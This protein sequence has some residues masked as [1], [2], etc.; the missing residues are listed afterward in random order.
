MALLTDIAIS[1]FAGLAPTPVEAVAIRKYLVRNQ[2][3]NLLHFVNIGMGSNI[4]NIQTTI[5][6][7]DAPDSA[8]FR[9][10]GEEYE[11]SNSEPKYVT[12]TLKLLG[13]EFSTDRALAKAFSNNESALDN[14]TDAQIAEKINSVI[15][16]FCKYFIQ[17]NSTTDAKQFDGLQ[18]YFTKHAGQKNDTPLTLVGGLTQANALS[19]EQFMNEAIAKVVDAPTCVLTTRLK[20]KPFLQAVESNRGRGYAKVKVGDLEYN[21]FMGLPIVALEDADFPAEMTDLGIPFIFCKFAEVNGIR[22]AVPMNIAANAA[23]VIDIVRPRVGKDGAGD[24]VFVTKGGVELMCVPV[25][26]DPYCAALC[27]VKETEAAG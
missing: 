12:L 3:F 10:I 2:L 27:F 17:G 5:V 18:V 20:G 15:N 22:V 21:S 16:A 1:G 4:G 26:E 11:V 25:I 6:T 8:E 23:A 24:S 19:V 14:W 7:Y 9:R 13:K